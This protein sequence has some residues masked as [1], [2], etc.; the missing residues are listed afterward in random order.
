MIHHRLLTPFDDPSVRIA[1]ASTCFSSHSYQKSCNTL[2]SLQHSE[3]FRH[4]NMETIPFEC[5]HSQI[6]WLKR[7]EAWPCD[8]LDSDGY[9]FSSWESC[10]RIF[11]F[12]YAVRC[13]LQRIVFSCDGEHFLG[14]NNLPEKC[15]F[16]W[17]NLEYW[18]RQGLSTLHS[19]YQ[20]RASWEYSILE[21]RNCLYRDFSIQFGQRKSCELGRLCRDLSILYRASSYL[22]CLE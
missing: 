7:A 9:M 12:A 2:A 18:N 15:R 11:S 1:L 20:E 22:K 4:R 10:F 6:Y 8:S 13:L 14:K 3:G 19:W 21:W 5:W 16:S 17:E